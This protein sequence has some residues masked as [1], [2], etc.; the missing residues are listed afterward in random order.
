[1]TK[2]SLLA[3]AAAL[4]LA[5]AAC[6]PKRLTLPTGP[7][8]P[9]ADY[10]APFDQAS[11]ACR[12][13]RTLR[14]TIALSGRAGGQRMRGT[15]LAGF[16]A[17]DAVRLEGVAPFGAPVFILVARGGSATLLLPRDNR[18]VTGV[19]AE[20][21]LEAIAGIRLDPAA[22]RA[23]LTGCIAAD[24]HPSAARAYNTSGPVKIG[25]GTTGYPRQLW[26]AID[27]D[28]GATAYLRQQ[29]GQWRIVAGLV[30][31]L[32]VEYGQFEG[33]SPRQVRILS[34]TNEPQKVPVN[35]GL[36]LS[37]VSTNITLN[38]AA[39]TVDVPS[40]AEPMTL[41][42]LREVGPLGEKR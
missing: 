3:A 17:P 23:I 34:R 11:A 12:G 33:G 38:P 42:E 8:T 37:D 16:E 26:L 13:I 29:Q 7:G 2:A 9:A 25:Y 18:V 35:I 27:I 1:M 19:S 28:P 6:A 31:G 39:F 36:A 21:I 4:A 40:G 14:A 20:D 15:L 32:E 10:Q 30:P 22:L 5:V 24:P 41:T